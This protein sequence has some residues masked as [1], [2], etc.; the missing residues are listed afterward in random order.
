MALCQGRDEGRVVEVRSNEVVV[1]IWGRDNFD[2]TLK[3]GRPAPHSGWWSKGLVFIKNS[4]GKKLSVL[5]FVC[6]QVGCI[7]RM[8]LQLTIEREGTRGWGWGLVFVVVVDVVVFSL[9]QALV[10]VLAKILSAL[11]LGQELQLSAV[12]GPATL[13]A[14]QFDSILVLH[15]QLNESNG[16]K[17]RRST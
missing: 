6:V 14:D 11:V 3:K 5:I 12:D 2:N 13:F 1:A 16:Y 15:A 8:Q 7:N 17:H 9:D 4:L 10:L